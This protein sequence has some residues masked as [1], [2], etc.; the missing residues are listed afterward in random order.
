[1]LKLSKDKQH[2][3][4]AI[5]NE[6]RLKILLVLWKSDKELTIYKLCVFTGL[7]RGSIIRH[8]RTLVEIMLVLKKYYGEIPLYTLN[9]QSSDVKALLD[10]FRKTRL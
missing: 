6:S 1:M 10:F 4:H 5:G 2:L 8:I 9:M 3:I 7:S